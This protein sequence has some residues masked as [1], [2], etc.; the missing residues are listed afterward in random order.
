MNSASSSFLVRGVG[1]VVVS[2]FVAAFADSRIE[3]ARTEGKA[4][5][6]LK[7]YEL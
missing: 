5:E 3:R 1:L 7:G 2:N 6:L 4:G